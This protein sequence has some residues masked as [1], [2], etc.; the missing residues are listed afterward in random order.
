MTPRELEAYE[1]LKGRLS[2]DLGRL[3]QHLVEQAQWTMDASE[4]AAHA[5][6]EKDEM[7]QILQSTKA[8]AARRIRNATEKKPSES[9]IASELLLEEEV[10]DAAVEVNNA[11]HKLALWR[12]LVD[13]LKA[14]A[15]SMKTA[16]E[17]INSGYLSIKS[18][19]EDSRA[20]LNRARRAR[21]G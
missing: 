13:A 4:F 20:E 9:Q 8:E 11:L 17:L 7:E 1:Q 21:D 3:D 14:K 15:S 2:L 12:G 19:R 10:M 5:A 16:G 6:K 18:V